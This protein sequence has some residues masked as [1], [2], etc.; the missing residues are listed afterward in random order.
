MISK[1]NIG[2]FEDEVA[3]GL[4]IDEY[5]S[6]CPRYARAGHCPRGQWPSGKKVRNACRKSCNMCVDANLGI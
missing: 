2:Q 1:G 4:C 3:N 6:H 5:E